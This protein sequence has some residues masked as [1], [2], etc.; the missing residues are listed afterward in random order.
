MLGDVYL[1]ATERPAPAG[2]GAACA[3]GPRVK[4]EDDRGIAIGRDDKGA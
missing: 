4:P 3:V 2:V 1:A